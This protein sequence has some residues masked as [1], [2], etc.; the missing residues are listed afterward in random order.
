MFLWIIGNHLQ[1]Y[2]VLQSQKTTIDIF[3]TVKTSNL[4]YWNINSFNTAMNKGSYYL[5]PHFW[6]VFIFTYR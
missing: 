3:T 6:T 2:T 1:D 4:M 5:Y